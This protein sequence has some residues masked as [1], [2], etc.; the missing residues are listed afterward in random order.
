MK[1]VLTDFQ[2]RTGKYKA[3]VFYAQPSGLRRAVL[4][5]T[6]LVFPIKDLK[7]S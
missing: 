3:L 6:I 2:V 4:E 5:N 7:L 1:P